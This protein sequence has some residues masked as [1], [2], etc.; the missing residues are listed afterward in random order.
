MILRDGMAVALHR[1][2]A[3]DGALLTLRGVSFEVGGRRILDRLDLTVAEGEI[4]ALIGINGSGKS[5]VAFVVMGCEGYLRARLGIT[6]AWHEPARFEGIIVRDFDLAAEVSGE[7]IDARVTV[8]AGLR[9]AN[10][11][12][13]CF[14]VVEA[15]GTQRIRM[16]VRLA[17]CLFPNAERV[18]LAKV[19]REAPLA[20]W[21]AS[22]SRR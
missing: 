17:H 7:A 9:V 1:C 10:P 2:D 22:S 3:M 13:L 19:T 18:L 4:H 20:A 11:I 8:R 6:L 14:G 5:T 15:S 16:Q 12:H 21:V